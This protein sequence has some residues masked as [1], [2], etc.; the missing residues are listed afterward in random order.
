MHVNTSH[1]MIIDINYTYH[2]DNA[3]SELSDDEF[4][5]AKMDQP[6][7]LEYSKVIPVKFKYNM[8]IPHKCLYN[9][10][11]LSSSN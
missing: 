7:E 2:S 3:H 10:L 9:G 1:S 6:S 5:S 4:I 11:P 8:S